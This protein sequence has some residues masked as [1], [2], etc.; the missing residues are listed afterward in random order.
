LHIEAP[1][2]SPSF[3]LVNEYAL[4]PGAPSG[5]LYH[6]D[7]YRLDTLDELETI[8]FSDIVNAPTDI[9]VVEWP[10]RAL[11]VLPERFLLVEI[12]SLGEGVRKLI[13]SAFPT[14]RAWQPRL[15]DLDRLRRAFLGEGIAQ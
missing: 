14:D 15:A 8:G 13:V 12:T 7:L 10:E 5:H 2:T 11:G 6:L 9:T 1:V 3:A 4:P